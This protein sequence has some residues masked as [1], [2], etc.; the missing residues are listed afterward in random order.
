METKFL[1]IKEN[2]ANLEDLVNNKGW[3]VKIALQ[4]PKG[5]IIGL[6]R[7]KSPTKKNK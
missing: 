3:S 4:H 6:E 2:L 7:P 5:V 1:L